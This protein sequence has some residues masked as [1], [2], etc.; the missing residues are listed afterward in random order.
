MGMGEID[1][2]IVCAGAKALIPSSINCER[3]GGAGTARGK[4]A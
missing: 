2:E 3:R 1:P 4:S